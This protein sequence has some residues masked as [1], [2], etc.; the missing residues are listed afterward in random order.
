VRPE[1]KLLHAVFNPDRDAPSARCPECGLPTGWGP[2]S[3][4]LESTHA[5]RLC[6][7]CYLRFSEEDEHEAETNAREREEGNT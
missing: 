2:D 7:E 6:A 3:E 1:D 5:A 4:F